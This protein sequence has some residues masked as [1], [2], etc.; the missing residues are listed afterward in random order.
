MGRGFVHQKKIGWI[1]EDFDQGETRFFSSTEDADG[2]KNIITTE[3]KG[4]ED[5]SGGLFAYGIRRIEDG[6]EHF[7]FHVEGVAAVLGKVA[8]AHVMSGGA[9]SAL[10]GDGP[11]EELEEGGFSCTVGTDENGALAAFGFKVEASVDDEITLAFD[12]AVGVIDIFQG[13]GAEPAPKGLRKGELD[14]TSGGN[15]SLNFIHTI[16]LLEFTLGLGGFTGLGAKAVGKL[17]EGGDFFSLIF[18]GGKVLLFA[19]GL[20]DYVLVVV[21]TVAVEFGLRNFDN[22]TDQLVE[23]FAVVGDHE[24]RPWIIS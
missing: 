1:E 18:V 17:L 20:F 2:F 14:G 9:F 11:A 21:T 16:D 15:G 23:K 13:D 24:N 10:D 19:G 22:G 12:I 4:T 6:F 5:S 3:K 8:D 7:V